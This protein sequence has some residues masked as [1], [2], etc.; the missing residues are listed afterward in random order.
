MNFKYKR[1]GV[2][3][4]GFYIVYFII[5]VLLA[6]VISW[7]LQAGSDR[8]FQTAYNIG[9]RI[10]V[11]VAIVYCTLLSLVILIA[12]KLYTKAMAVILFILSIIGALLMSNLLGC[13][14]PAILSTF[15]AKD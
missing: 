14:F 13:I 10:G 7:L 11:Y 12:K 6:G 5:G 15:E 4:I 9:V 2:Q 8:D 3:A 1:T